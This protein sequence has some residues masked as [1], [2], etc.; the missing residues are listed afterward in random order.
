LFSIDKN[1]YIKEHTKNGCEAFYIDNE[2]IIRNIN[3]IEK[4][5]IN[6][7]EIPFTHGGHSRGNILNVMASVAAVSSFY[8]NIEEIVHTLI[9]LQCDLSFNPG[10]QNILDFEKFKVILDYG[11]NSEA[12]REVFSIA[13]SLKPSRLTGIIAAAG[14]RM[15]KYISELGTIA[16]EYCNNIIIREQADLRGRRPG[17]SASLIKE[18]AISGGF[19]EDNL[20][21][22]YK[23]EDAIVYAMENAQQGEVIV[24][25]TQC[26]DVVIPA[27]N[28][29]MVAKGKTLIGE[30][31]DF[32]H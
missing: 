11:H 15:D 18:G 5:L 3:G 20:C 31:V 26:L 16:S 22:I 2:F 4:K 13:K 25:F 30:G 6:L 32:S 24:L 19:N 1:S 21:I 12:F 7:K 9:D 10:R 28:K 14:D 29:L 8:E 27:I 23:E 17:E